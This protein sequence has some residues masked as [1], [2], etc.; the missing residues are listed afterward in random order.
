MFLSVANDLVSFP[1]RSLGIS[2]PTLLAYMI[3]L[4]TAAELYALLS[5]GLLYVLRLQTLL[6]GQEM[7]MI[8]LGF[9]SFSSLLHMSDMN[10][11]QINVIVHF[12]PFSV[13]ISFKV[14]V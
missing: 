6:Q 3:L 12:T 1:Y 11:Q 5:A 10:K 13:F 9:A 4:S 14:V 2:V 8:C 7:S